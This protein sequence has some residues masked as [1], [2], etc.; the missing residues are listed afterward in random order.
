MPPHTVPADN[1]QL[2]LARAEQVAARLESESS[3]AAERRLTE[4]RQRAE[5]ILAEARAEAER[6]V[7]DARASAEESR[8]AVATFAHEAQATARDLEQL[9]SSLRTR[10]PTPIERSSRWS[11]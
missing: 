7:R 8:R 10:F 5:H 4:A 11:R 9:A 6:I 1:A 3:A 2:I